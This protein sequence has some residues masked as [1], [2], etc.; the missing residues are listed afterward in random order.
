M[1]RSGR[2]WGV[3]SANVTMPYSHVTD[4]MQAEAATRLDDVLGGAI[5]GRKAGIGAIR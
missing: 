4:T 3:N 2:S 5:R 1:K